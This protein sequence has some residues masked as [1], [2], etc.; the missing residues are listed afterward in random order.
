MIS[1]FHSVPKTK[2]EPSISID[3]MMTHRNSPT[4]N[5]TTLNSK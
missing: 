2:L 4:L 5:D 3:G 1:R